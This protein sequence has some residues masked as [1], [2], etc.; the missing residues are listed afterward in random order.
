MRAKVYPVTVNLTKAQLGKIDL[1][2]QGTGVPRDQL[3][4]QLVESVQVYERPV[5]IVNAPQNGTDN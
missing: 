1:I 5:L 4:G 2:A 3:F